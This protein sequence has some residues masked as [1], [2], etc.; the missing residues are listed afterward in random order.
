MS[1]IVDKAAQI[2]QVIRRKEDQI[3]N[4]QADMKREEK[5]KSFT[6]DVYKEKIETLGKEI[7]VL[8]DEYN[9]LV[10]KAA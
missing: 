5:D 3:R 10:N 4:F 1:E 6:D 9:S 2:R 8:Q 7:K